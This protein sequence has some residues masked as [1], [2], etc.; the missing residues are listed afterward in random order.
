MPASLRLLLSAIF[1]LVAASAAD[2]R[3]SVSDLRIGRH[4]DKTRFVVEISEEPAYRVFTLANPYRVVIDLSEFDLEAEL[5][6]EKLPVG[7]IRDLRSGLF[8]PGTS[9]IVLDADQP[10]RLAE[11][12]VLPPS[13]GHLYRLV[14]DLEEVSRQVYAGLG[15]QAVESGRFLPAESAPQPTPAPAGGEQITIV[16]DP[17]HGGVD[18]GAISVSGIYKKHIT[19]AYAKELK[20]QLE[21]TGKYRVLLTRDRDV[22]VKLDDRWGFAR[23]AGASL[24]LSLHADSHH[25]HDVRG[26]SVFTLSSEASDEVAAA[27]AES[28][29]RA[30][31]VAG[32]DLSQHSDDVSSILLDLTRRETAN[33]S[34]RYASMLVESLGKE[35]RLLRNPHRFAGFV[36]LKAHDVPSVLVE[37]GFLSNPEDE[38]RLRSNQHRDR[39]TDAIADSIDQYFEWQQALR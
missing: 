12:F 20:H 1:V 27:L 16:I 13:D 37:I 2:A 33:F 39:I 31:L 19:L 3:P 24:F 9:R 5:A 4:P 18:P 25:S 23:E 11:V 21:T 26:A 15:D 28:A 32:V 6:E 36:V 30:D 8:T 29:N 7:V 38:K 14:I 35:T 34:A 10:V 17:G 22:F